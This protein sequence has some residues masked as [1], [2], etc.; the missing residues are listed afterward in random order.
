[1]AEGLSPEQ[2]RAEAERRLI[3]SGDAEALLRG[4]ARKREQRIRVRHLMDVATHEVR[5]AL[6]SLRKQPGITALVVITL[7]L[8]ISTN[9]SIFPLVDRLLFRTP[10]GIES[11]GEVH[12]LYLTKTRVPG[13]SRVW[14]VFSYPEVRDLREAFGDRAQIA[15]FMSGTI[16]VAGDATTARRVG[17]AYVTENFLPLL[18]VRIALGRHIGVDD[19]RLD[20]PE[21]VAIISYDVWQSRFGGDSALIGQR[22]RFGN[23][24]FTI[25][26][27]TARGFAGI[28]VVRQ[29]CGYRSQ[30]SARFSVLAA[31]GGKRE[32][33]LRGKPSHACRVTL[34]GRRSRR[35]R[36]RV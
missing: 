10:P 29:A 25:I 11:P 8:G 28:D 1:M 9:A 35:T 7:A 32:A 18:G 23:R 26:G 31:L 16:S 34:P 2:A 17:L 19:N 24:E 12:R 21:L 27:V 5:Y 22:K 20:R 4:A 33:C 6:R 36:W 15:A 14:E 13:D 3:A 30:P